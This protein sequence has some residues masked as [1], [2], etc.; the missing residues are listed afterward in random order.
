MSRR[1]LSFAFRKKIYTGQI[2][3]AM[4]FLR[5]QYSSCFIQACG[6]GQEALEAYLPALDFY[7]RAWKRTGFARRQEQRWLV[8]PHPHSL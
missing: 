5:P 1:F 7:P 8:C 3:K 6:G 4:Q 2:L